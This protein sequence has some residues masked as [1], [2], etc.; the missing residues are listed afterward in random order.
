MYRRLSGKQLV[1]S[2]LALLL[3]I[4]LI[5]GTI[6]LMER[7]ENSRQ[8]ALLKQQAEQLSN[9]LW[10]DE[11]T[12]VI[13]GDTFGFDHRMET[14]LF[15]GTDLSGG[16][17][18][19][20]GD[21][22]RQPM[23]DFLLLLVLDHTRDSI[24]FLQIDR[25]TVTP[26][27]ALDEAG[28]TTGIRPL[29]ICT[30]H[31]YGT[32]E[33]M[34]AE[35][36]TRA[37]R[38]YLGDLENIDGYYVIGL[39]DI[40]Q[41]NSAVGGVDITLDEDLTDADP[42]FTKGASLHLTDAQAHTYLQARMN[43][44]DGTN[45][46]R[47]ARQRSYMT[48]LF[49]SV[50][51]KSMADP[52]FALTLWNTLRSAA[53]TNMNGNDFSRIAQ[54]LI[55]G[56]NQ[57]IRTIQGET[58]E[59]YLTGDGLPHEEFYADTASLKEQLISLFNLVPVEDTADS[60]SDTEDE[61]EEEWEQDPDEEPEEET[62]DEP[63]EVIPAVEDAPEIMTSD[64]PDNGEDEWIPDEDEEPETIPGDEGGEGQA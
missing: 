38:G 20:S 42:A 55:K 39:E 45:V 16:Q 64:S 7:Y 3:V 34:A 43:V 9:S 27:H 57:G 61:E 10:T 25:N 28:N 32:T 8:A 48:G 33:E 13:D 59:G 6:Y 62:S 50:R 40:E 30:A 22:T 36:L 63:E 46:A 56:E 12:L 15:V 35:N 17:K 52:Q 49:E 58:K 31:W 54:K 4:S 21:K 44:S 53:F 5:V 14:F 2:V 47:M 1:F 51:Q 37:V 26:V 19:G 60:G 29:Q 41:L 11:N 23:A 18:V 24:G